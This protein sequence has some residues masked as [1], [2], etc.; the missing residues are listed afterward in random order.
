MSKSMRYLDLIN[1]VAASKGV[2][3]ELPE[4]SYSSIIKGDFTEKAEDMAHQPN[5]YCRID[6]MVNDAKVF[7][8]MYL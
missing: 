4:S 8:N 6:D 2:T 1:S 3:L 7:A 5:E